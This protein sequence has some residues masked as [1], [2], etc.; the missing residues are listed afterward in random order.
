MTRISI[1]L[2]LAGTI[3]SSSCVTCLSAEPVSSSAEKGSISDW[4]NWRGPNNSG[5]SN[6]ATPPVQWS[7]DENI[8]WKSTIP[9]KGSSTPIVYDNKVFI[10]TAEKTDRVKEGAAPAANDGEVNSDA[11]RRPRDRTDDGTQP[12]PE[13]REG[14]PEQARK[15]KEV[16]VAPVADRV[17]DLAVL[18]VEAGDAKQHPKITIVSKFLLTI[19]KPVKSYGNKPLPRKSHMKVSTAPTTLLRR[20]PQPTENTST[21]PLD[22]AVCFAMTSKAIRSGKKT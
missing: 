9:G 20:H 14:P 12:T 19:S 10:L 3:A 11:P 18:A 6:T 15:T 4:P 22:L 17:A 7:A 1:V 5:A 8:L 16:V 21:L 13:R 2:G